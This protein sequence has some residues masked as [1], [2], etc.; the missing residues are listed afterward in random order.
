MNPRQNKADRGS[1]G[2]PA[3][4]GFRS[5]RKRWTSRVPRSRTGARRMRAPFFLAPSLRG[6]PLFRR[7]PFAIAASLP[8]HYRRGRFAEGSDHLCRPPQALRGGSFWARQNERR[9]RYHDAA[10]AGTAREVFTGRKIG[11]LSPEEAKLAHAAGYEPD[12]EHLI[13]RDPRQMNSA[14]LEAMGHAPMSPVEA[15][16]AK[17][18]DCAGLSDEV[19]NAWRW[20]ARPGRS[21]WARTHGERFRMR[22]AR[23]D[24][25]SRPDGTRNRLKLSRT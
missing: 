16:R 20:R 5:W 12:G 11:S 21:V 24:V 23:S 13:G 9:L 3:P 15:I 17:C 18:L 6:L 7:R 10:R 22:G 14:E 1:T 25:D 19:P 4:P 8:M 2:R